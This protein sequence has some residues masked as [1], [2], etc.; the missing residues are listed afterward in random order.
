M[1][2]TA[3]RAA[4]LK[5]PEVHCHKERVYPERPYRM[6][7]MGAPGT[8]KGTQAELLSERFCACHL[9]TGDVFRAARCVD[10]SFTSPAMQRA[11]E[12]MQRGELVPDETVL[13]LVRERVECL[14]CDYGFVF[15]GFPRTVAQAVSL[16]AL[17]ECAGVVLDAVISYELPTHEVVERLGGRRTCRGC[18]ATWHIRHKPPAREGVCDACGGELYQRVDDNPASIAVR[19]QAYEQTAGPLRDYYRR[20]NLLLSICAA[21]SPQEVFEQTLL[22]MQAKLA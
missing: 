7:L 17:F 12:C 21:G 16:D 1:S 3:D 11:L 6:I 14:K 19:L 2:A 8:G 13:E 15:D 10:P 22:A 5:G 20:K 4:W 18:G 9:S